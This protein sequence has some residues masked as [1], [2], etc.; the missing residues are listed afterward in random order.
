[1]GRPIKRKRY[2]VKTFTWYYI[3]TFTGKH[4]SFWTF[5]DVEIVK[6]IRDWEQF[7]AN[8]RGERYC[9][10]IDINTAAI[11]DYQPC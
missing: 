3:A 1:M 2:F 9:G 11:V 5:T 10:E 6:E 8:P 4:G 7:K